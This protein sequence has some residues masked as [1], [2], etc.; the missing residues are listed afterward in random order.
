MTTCVK[1]EMVT[2]DE[3]EA[4]RSAIQVCIPSGLTPIDTF[5][6]LKSAPDAIDYD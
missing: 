2:S 5:C 6:Q 4:H 3:D 1:Q